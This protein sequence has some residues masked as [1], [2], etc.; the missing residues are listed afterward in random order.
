MSIS[1]KLS[2]YVARVAAQFKTVMA[3]ID[4]VTATANSTKNTVDGL[5]NVYA[6]KS[7]THTIANVESLQTTLN[8][9][10]PLASPAFTGTPTAPTAT[11]GTNTTQV[12]TTAFVTTAV[13]NKTS[14]ASA[15]KATQ[16]GSGN[17]ITST[18]ATKASLASVAT[19]GKY[20]DLSG[21]PTTLKNPTSI[22]LQNSAGTSI[23]SYDGATATTIKLTAST[24]G[25]GNVTNESKSTMFTSPTFTGTP[26]APTAT[27]GTN[28]TQIATTA[29]VAT[30]VANLV[31]SAPETLDTLGELATALS[32]NVEVTTALNTAIGKKAN[33]SDVVKL[34]GNQTIAGTKTFSSTISGSISGN[35]AT[36]TKATQDG[37]GNVITSTY[38]TKTDA[39]NSY[40]GKT[41]KASSATTAD[42]ATKATQDASGNVITSTYATKTEL[43]GKA[44][45]ATSLSGYGITDA[46]TKN[47]TKSN[48]VEGV[49]AQGSVNKDVNKMFDGKVYMV[50]QGSN[51]PTGSQ[52]GV[53]MGMPYRKLTGNEIPDFG[54][55]IFI[56]NGD[57]DTHPNSMF[58]RTSLSDKWN[59]WQEVA[60][61]NDII[62]DCFVGKIE[63]FYGTLDSTGKH[64]L[65]GGS[66][67]TN[68][69]ICDGTNGTPDLRGKFVRGAS[70]SVALGT[71]GGSSDTE[72]VD[73]DSFDYSMST[74]SVV[75]A[76]DI[77][78]DLPPYVALYY[79][80]KIA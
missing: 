43:A 12:A 33:D 48:F 66:A 38:L 21:T 36:A 1:T 49:D 6:P 40:L 26:K 41:A 51:C 27:A 69:Q 79:I 29:F 35:A 73:Q 42:S 17:V 77:Q 16:D 58:Y 55:Q 45:S 5:G 72:T 62:S 28:T 63:M 71:T 8:A 18:Y 64:P 47:Q 3:S 9:K 4:A 34:S 65:V 61:K 14:V 46:Y 11:A 31:N 67:R 44:S 59:S 2:A 75:T 23:G 70:S 52:Y 53:V 50:K 78:T 74:G 54:A 20:S 25:L 60:T 32:E 80:M 39:S 7:H 37:S 10:A 57:D 22:T 15:T 19:S 56:P 30:A 68:W 76:M 24:V 13:A